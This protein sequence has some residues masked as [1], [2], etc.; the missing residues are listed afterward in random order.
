METHLF[1]ILSLK[2]DLECT[3]TWSLSKTASG[4]DFYLLKCSDYLETDDQM[5]EFQMSEKEKAERLYD[6]SYD[7]LE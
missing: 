7:S 4:T 6:E 5:S 3:P 1:E 2:S